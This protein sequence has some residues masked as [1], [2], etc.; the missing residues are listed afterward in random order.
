MQRGAWVATKRT[1]NMVLRP[2]ISSSFF[3]NPS[4]QQP[5]PPPPPPGLFSMLWK[6]ASSDL[7]ALCS[8]SQ[9]LPDIPS[10]GSYLSLEGPDKVGPID[11]VLVSYSLR[12]KKT[13]PRF[14]SG[15]MCVQAYPDSNLGL[16]VFFDGGSRALS[17]S[18]T[19]PTSINCLTTVELKLLAHEVISD[20]T[21]SLSLDSRAW[22]KLEEGMSSQTLPKSWSSMSSPTAFEIPNGRSIA[23]RGHPSST[24]FPFLIPY[25]FSI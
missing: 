1:S 14:K 18:S 19:R 13:N 23:Q 21:I 22:S 25:Y 10:L 4:T 3:S 12:P 24:W 17:Y 11:N 7:Q 16:V 20:P 15:H 6:L 8:I 5:P 9:S 2:P